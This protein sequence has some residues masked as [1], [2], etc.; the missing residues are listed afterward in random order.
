MSVPSARLSPTTERRSRFSVR[1]LVT[2]LVLAAAAMGLVAYIVKSADAQAT[3]VMVTQPVPA[4]TTVQANDIQTI[5]VPARSVAAGAITNPSQIVGQLTD[6][7]LY[8]N[9]QITTQELVSS[10]ESTSP[11]A[12][13]LSQLGDTNLRAVGLSADNISFPGGTDI[14]AGDHIDIVSTASFQVSGNNNQNQTVNMAKVILSDVPVLSVQSQGSSVSGIIVAVTPTQA[15]ELLYLQAN[16]K[17]S[18]LLDP[19]TPNTG[20]AN[21]AP[22]VTGNWLL[23][24]LNVSPQ[25]GSTLSQL[26]PA[27][28][29]PPNSASSSSHKKSQGT[30]ASTPT[31]GSTN[32][33]P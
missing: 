4:F 3:V 25:G 31:S 7:T 32:S 6:T 9:V 5:S 18:F 22:T 29:T 19:F 13:Q 28:T 24:Q 15:V 20:A 27:A 11:L 23:N 33:V 10:N 1:L 8:P 21:S 16:G 17:L 12:A 30:Q 26:P 14:V 2:G